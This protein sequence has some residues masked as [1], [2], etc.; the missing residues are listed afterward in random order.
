[1]V[2]GTIVPKEQ[3]A[4]TP[5]GYIGS[6]PDRQLLGKA[7][8]LKGSCPIRQLPRKTVAPKAVTPKGSCSQRRR[9]RKTVTPKAVAP[10]RGRWQGFGLKID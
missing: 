7:V 6:C 2:A 4:V 9:H 5:K 10:K 3:K 1:M 8:T